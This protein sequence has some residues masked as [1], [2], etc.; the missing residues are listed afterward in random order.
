M[1]MDRKLKDP[2]K[3]EK[4][5][6][7]AAATSKGLSHARR[8]GFVCQLWH[9]CHT[10]TITVLEILEAVLLKNVSMVWLI[11]ISN[12]SLGEWYNPHMFCGHM[13][14]RN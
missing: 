9:T 10:F 4:G 5:G 3:E 13:S 11:C 14:M 6:I 1:G 7:P 12:F 2:E 8:K